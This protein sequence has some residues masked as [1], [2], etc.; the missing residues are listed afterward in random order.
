M[1]YKKNYYD[2]IAYVKTLN[3][4]KGDGNYYEKHHIVPRSLGGKDT[5]NNLVLL[6]AREHYLAHYLLWKFLP[7]KSTVYAFMLMNSN[8]ER[9][10]VHI[11]SSK[12]YEE[13][14]KQ[15]TLESKILQ[16]KRF[17][18]N[19]E[20]RKIVGERSKGNKSTKG[21]KWFTN[22]II[23]TVSD[24]CPDGFI[25]G[26]TYHN[27]EETRKK[28]KK[29]KKGKHPWNYGKSGYKVP[30]SKG[31][32]RNIETRKRMSENRPKKAVL[33][34][35]LNGNFIK[36]YPSQIEAERQTGIPNTNISYCCNGKYSQAGG[37]IWK[38]KGE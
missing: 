28:Q 19:P 12:M 26:M 20:L 38:R 7:C 27:K 24:I 15:F 6:T 5:E 25:L 18:N 31:K 34:F 14:R 11:L 3:R 13:I 8:C 29:N 33:Q 9:K 2:Y 1:N 23:N 17:E 16:K 22:G 10:S 32:K 30:N 35:D 21:K 37:F 4:Y 36:E